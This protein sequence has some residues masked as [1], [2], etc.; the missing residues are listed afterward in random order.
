MLPC[1][2]LRCELCGMP[3]RLCPDLHRGLPAAC[4]SLYNG[5]VP[6]SL[7]P[8]CAETHVGFPWL[9]RKSNVWGTTVPI[10]LRDGSYRGPG[11]TRRMLHVQSLTQQSVFVFFDGVTSHIVQLFP[12]VFRHWACV[13]RSVR[14]LSQSAVGS[15]ILY[16][17]S[18]SIPVTVLMTVP[19]S[20]ALIIEG[21]QVQGSQDPCWRDLLQIGQ[22]CF[23]EEDLVRLGHA[24]P[25]LNP[26]QPTPP[27]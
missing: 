8:F 15:L 13:D 11:L 9:V 6:S 14:G 4:L 17:A 21:S 2:P 25:T 26:T 5:D 1:K 24:P 12:A 7:L 20:K 27:S 23:S 22:H 3:C 16:F 10:A 18:S 19:I